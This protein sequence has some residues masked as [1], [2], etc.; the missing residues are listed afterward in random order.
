MPYIKKEER[1]RANQ[2]PRNPGELNFCL[3]CLSLD[4][5][6]GDYDASEFSVE[7]IH[8]LDDYLDHHP[9]SYETFNAMMGVLQCVPLELERRLNADYTVQV[10]QVDREFKAQ[11][12]LFYALTMAPYEDGKCEAHGDVYPKPMTKE[13]T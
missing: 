13:L 9:R 12:D 3:T 8:A 6:D 10:I 7:I 5:M 4:Y 11:R 1:E 2:F